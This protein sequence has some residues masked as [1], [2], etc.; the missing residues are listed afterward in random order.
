MSDCTQTWRERVREARALRT[1]L[2]LRGGGSKDF[3]G[4]QPTGELFDTREHHGIVNYEPTELV[5]TV[6]AGT[7]LAEL[8]ALLASHRQ[9]LAFEP[10]CFGGRATVG[11]CVAAGL[12]GPR[13][14]A[15]GAVRDFVLGVRVIDGRGEVL[16]F[17]GEVMKNVAGYDVSRLM[18]GS[19]GTLGLLLDVS[20]KVLPR[21]LREISLRQ[22]RDEAGAID[23]MN[24][25]AGQPLP[26]SATVW[27][28]G[29]L[30]V[31]LS[32]SDEALDAAIDRVGG[33]LL[34]PDEATAFWASVTEQQLA[35]F[36]DTGTPLW[37]V[38]VPGTAPPLALPGEQLI[39]WSGGLRWVRTTLAE[40]ELRARVQALGG[41][42]L[43]FR[44]GARD[45]EVFHPLSAPLMTVHRRLKQA[46]DPDGLFNPG[47][48][49]Q[50]I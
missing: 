8:D 1:P 14:M 40:T 21:P 5:V 48:L 30:T 49:Y 13:R 2:R 42:A 9:M 17:G 43:R 46:F 25:W 24:R 50:G 10:P 27:H 20:L 3:Y 26:V 35:F 6:R 18:A 32:G 47:R 12:S 11:G 28:D 16:S 4:R 41:H 38:A 23:L 19:L 37:R 45:G 36:A 44:G 22:R 31:R 15:A 29:L 7:P 39:E 33:D 34:T